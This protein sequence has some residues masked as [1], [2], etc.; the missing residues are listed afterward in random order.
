MSLVM[1]KGSPPRMTPAATTL[2]NFLPRRFLVTT[3]TT[4]ATATPA[5]GANKKMKNPTTDVSRLPK[6]EMT[7][8]IRNPHR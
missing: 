7:P 2:N 3:L 5:A 4:S 1:I 6:N 8:A